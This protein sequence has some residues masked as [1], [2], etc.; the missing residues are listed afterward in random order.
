MMNKLKLHGAN[1]MCYLLVVFAL[2]T[3]FFLKLYSQHYRRPYVSMKYTLANCIQVSPAVLVNGQ[4]FFS[5][6][7]W[8]YKHAWFIE[9]YVI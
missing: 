7:T 8:R 1:F 9:E 6:K 5:I 4:W 2:L 3:V